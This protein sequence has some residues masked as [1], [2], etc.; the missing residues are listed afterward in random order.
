MS[1]HTH[2]LKI[3]MKSIPY[4]LTLFLPFLFGLLLHLQHFSSWDVVFG[5]KLAVVFDLRL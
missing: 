4:L 5:F 1:V 3:E 2:T